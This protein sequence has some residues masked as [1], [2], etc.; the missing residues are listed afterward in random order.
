[1]SSCGGHFPLNKISNN[2]NLLKIVT[3]EF[4]NLK[5]SL[6]TSWNQNNRKSRLFVQE[7]D[8]RLGPNQSK[9]LKKKTTEDGEL[10]R[11]KQFKVDWDLFRALYPQAVLD[12]NKQK[13]HEA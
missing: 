2:R 3:V 7:Q 11:P 8:E 10:F 6:P 5:Q 9:M 4:N 12:L 1:M 13:G